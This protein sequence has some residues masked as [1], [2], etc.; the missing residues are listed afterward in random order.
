MYTQSASVAARWRRTRR[1]RLT[2]VALMAPAVRIRTYGAREDEKKARAGL[3]ASSNTL[4]HKQ[5]IGEL[6]INEPKR[7]REHTPQRNWY[8]TYH[9]CGRSTQSPPKKWQRWRQTR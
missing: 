7:Q 9:I 8:R 2:A 3:L 5:C 6:A 1:E 4:G